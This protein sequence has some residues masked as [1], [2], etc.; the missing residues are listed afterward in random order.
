M[1]FTHTVVFGVKGIAWNDADPD[2]EVLSDAEAGSRV[3]LVSKTDA[4]TTEGDRALASG[5]LMLR[6]LV[7]DDLPEGSIEERIA[8]EVEQI[9]SSR[10]Q[11]LGRDPAI[12][13]SIRGEVDDIT[14]S[15]ERDLGSFVVCF[16]GIDKD[17]IRERNAGVIWAT[18]TAITLA[19]EGIVELSKVADSLV[20]QRDDGKSVYPYALQAGA[21][22]VVVSKPLDSLAR[23]EISSLYR[24]LEQDTNFQRVERLLLAARDAESDNLRRFLAGWSALEIFINKVFPLY[25]GQ[26]LSRL[27]DESGRG[28]GKSFA[29]RIRSV[30]R[31]KYGLVDKFAAIAFLLSPDEAGED[32]EKVKRAKRSRNDLIHGGPVNEAALPVELVVDLAGRYL[33]R[34]LMTRREAKGNP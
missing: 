9:R 22:R 34:H 10:A 31:D 12:V 26:L 16:D 3:M 1:Q 14:P 2:L 8:R 24:V 15:L 6:G 23:N 13:I 27:S 33:R 7:S 32:F 11:R 21:G 4:Y 29:A 17:S 5:G 19:T 30:M 18:L 25:E 28:A 20:L